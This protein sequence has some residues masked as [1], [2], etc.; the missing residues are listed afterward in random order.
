ME[1]HSSFRPGMVARGAI[2]HALSQARGGR[3]VES[4]PPEVGVLMSWMIAS[5]LRFGRLVI[6]AA[7]ALLVLG[8]AQL[9][10][11]K[12][13]VYPEFMPPTV[14][15]QTE[16]LGLSAAEVEHFITLGME[17]DLL[18]GVPW[19]KSIHSTSMPG[20]SVVDL[21]F[22][23]G[24]DLY[25][26]RQMV[27]ERMTQARVLPNVGSAPV[28]I[29]PLASTGRVAMIGLS[30]TS[31]SPIDLSLLARW[32]LRP[33]LMGVPGVANVAVYGMR[34]RQLQVTVDPAKL[35]Q[36]KVTLT[37]VIETAG[38]SLWVSPLTF[39]EA[40]TPGTGGFVEG[41]N[42]RLAIQHVSPIS[43]PEQL[44][45][46]PVQDNKSVRLG[47]VAN[48]IEDHQPLIGD[49]EVAGAPSLFL[50]IQKY[51]GTNTLEVTRNIEKAMADL[52]PGLRG[53]TVTSDVYRPATFIQTALGNVRLVALVGFL[54]LLG[55]FLVAFTSL[56]AAVI[57]V[58]TVPVSL[59]AAAYLLFL[60]GQTFTTM[61]LLG[62]AVAVA[63]VIDDAVLDTGALGRRLRGL[64]PDAPLRDRLD[65]VGT[66]YAESRGPLVFATLV[67]LLA[68]VPLLVTSSLTRA[69]ST[70]LVLTFALALAASMLV[71]LTLTPALA[72]LL[73]R[74]GEPARERP[75]VRWVHAGFDR[76]AGRWITRPAATAGAIV[77]LVLA[78][79][80]V[81]PQLGHGRVLPSLQDRNLLV[82]VDAAAGTSL[83]EMD[84]IG[85]RASQELRA[86]PG[87]QD[88][89]VHVGRAVSSDQKVDTNSAELWVNLSESADYAATRDA[90]RSVVNGYPGLRSS[91]LTYA[92]G[93][94]AAAGHSD[95]LVVRVYGIDLDPL[96]AKAEE[97]RKAITAVPGLVSPRLRPVV[98]QP[99]VQ[100]DVDVNK[101]QKYGLKPGDV[102]RDAT[103]LTSGL[104]VGNLYEQA[105]IF[106]VVVW[107][108]AQTRNS[109]TDLQNL[110]LDTPSG[111]QVRLQ[112][113]ATVSIKPQPTQISHDEV[114][115]DA[116]VVASIHGRDPDQVVADV[117]AR[118]ARVSMPYEYH[119]EVL[120][121]ATVR[122]SGLRLVW[123][124]VAAALIGILLLCQAA[125]GSWR[126]SALLVLV[127]PLAVA[128]GALTA[129]LAGGAGSAGALAGLFVVFALAVR[130]GL[131]LLRRIRALQSE[132]G[133]GP[134]S[135]VVVEATREQAVPVLRSALAVALMVLP[136]AVL[137]SRAGLEL[138]HPLAVTVLG[139]LVSLVLVLLLV[140][141]ALNLLV[142]SPSTTHQLDRQPETAPEP[143]PV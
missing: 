43:T 5:G 46:V 13:D 72:V 60:A 131:L 28:M 141:P 39:V 38:N 139:G 114:L 132:N 121:D 47:D 93:Q 135:H 30:S 48:V 75:F 122:Q 22:E 50:V 112:D 133:W 109:L 107:G 61:T 31:V 16:A 76:T 124:F 84:R 138:L 83:T 2:P 125:T 96:R 9:G 85:A 119:A 25:A 87:V 70:P 11:A 110:L 34:D 45:A 41:A 3:T 82:Q 6:A 63:L 33:R 8:V 23:P 12:V 120:G 37:Q 103:T 73:L 77:V 101:A 137:G 62:L 21:L 89:G 78:G 143:V 127:L 27:T 100:I 14:E 97:I 108:T 92:D 52:A 88:V 17:Q 94:L 106:D 105:T 10:S 54:L 26:A 115:R 55:L 65:A 123:A 49:A 18:N 7:I 71:A 66:G 116:E 79:L 19:L 86:L 67:V 95:D 32:K 113:V 90:I 36:N 74:T 53:I 126:R 130:G 64:P 57:A 81:I 51:P 98:Q 118:V 129:P 56:R 140:L 142:P 128:G 29:E 111:A 20:L 102:R 58:L 104:I 44:A 35:H 134:A 1:H 91:V 117:K 68:T 4:R 59:V 69:F 42:Q 136:A 80:A 15:I 40:S 24:T 99:T